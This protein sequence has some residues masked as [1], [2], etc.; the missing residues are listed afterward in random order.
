MSSYL[1]G[2]DAY[3]CAD[4][5]CRLLEGLQAQ[6]SSLV[7]QVSMPLALLPGS[8]V[9]LETVPDLINHQLSCVPGQQSLCK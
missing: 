5:V 1:L 4:F 6:L 3:V 8:N 9:L 2:H 7:E